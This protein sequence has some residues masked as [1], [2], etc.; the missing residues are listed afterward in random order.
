M[1]K[2]IKRTF[3][4]F[5]VVLICLTGYVFWDNV[6]IKVAKESI[7]IERL[8]EGLEDF[9]ILQISDLHEQEFGRNQKRLIKKI[10]EIDYDVLVITGD[11]VDNPESTHYEPL[12]VLLEGIVNKD[13]VLFVSGNADPPSYQL[14][15]RFEKSEFISGIEDRGGRFLES[16]D[17][18]D[19]SGERIHF[20]N[21]EMAIIR[22]PDQIGKVNGTFH[23]VHANEEA[24]QSYQGKLW[25]EM[26][27]RDILNLNEPV[28]AL[29]HYPVV[30]KRIEYIK[31]D[32]AT[33]WVNFDLIIAGHYHGGQIRLPFL[34][35]LFVPEPWYEPHSFFPPQDRVK[36]LWEYDQTKQYVS[37]GLGTSDALP[38]LK[39]RLFNPPEIN[40]I[41]LKSR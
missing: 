28:I 18:I 30:D 26:T 19:V 38:L 27:N 25:E 10:N 34:G 3:L 21:L 37:A 40:V 22:K 14:E 8:S 9:T 32:P 7:T 13:N 24:Y 11:V 2:I 4:G 35:A 12:Y 39:F 41:T 31:K 6:R 36:G 33:D 5:L 23:P 15:P 29:N 16:Y 20:V 17:S 1:R